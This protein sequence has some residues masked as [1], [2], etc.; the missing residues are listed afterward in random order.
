MMTT[1]SQPSIECALPSEDHVRGIASR[2]ERRDPGALVKSFAT[3]SC[4]RNQ[5][6]KV[7]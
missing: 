4:Y 1:P 6:G 3:C 5:R 7:N 2:R